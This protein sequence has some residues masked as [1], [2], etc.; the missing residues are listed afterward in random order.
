M[1]NLRNLLQT[2]IGNVSWD[3]PAWIARS[4]AK[5]M[6]ALMVMLVIVCCL[7]AAFAA[8]YWYA[9]RPYTPLV[10]VKFNELSIP[11]PSDTFQEPSALCMTFGTYPQGGGDLNNQSLIPL[12][13]KHYQEFSNAETQITPA[14]A[15]QWRWMNDSELCFCSENSVASW[16]AL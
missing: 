4:L 7:A 8:R 10:T 2:L 16:A 3:K 15:G 14:I 9:H 5:P 11:A 1:K 12:N 6:R 13:A